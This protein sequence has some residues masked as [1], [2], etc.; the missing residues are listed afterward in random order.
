MDQAV[1]IHKMNVDAKARSSCN[2]PF[3]VGPK[4][5]AE[6]SMLFSAWQSGGIFLP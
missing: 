4:R 3:F 1:K 2:G 5:W 6:T